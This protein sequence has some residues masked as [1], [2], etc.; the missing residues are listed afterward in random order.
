[1]KI[2]RPGGLKRTSRANSGALLASGTAAAVLPTVSLCD[3]SWPRC[4]LRSSSR[5]G[6][7]KPGVAKPVVAEGP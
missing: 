1:M 6:R 5:S 2:N 4:R 3:N 7:Q